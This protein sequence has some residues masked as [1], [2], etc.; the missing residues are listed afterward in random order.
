MKVEVKYASDEGMGSIVL[1]GLDTDEEIC[2]RETDKTEAYQ[3][4]E[5]DI[6][7]E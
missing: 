5:I 6:E 2:R 7:E 1:K 3:K 4:I